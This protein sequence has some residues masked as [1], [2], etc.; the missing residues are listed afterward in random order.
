MNNMIFADRLLAIFP[1]ILCYWYHY[2]N[3]GIRIETQ[4]EEESL[5]GHFLALL[6]PKKNLPI[7][8]KPP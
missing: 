2:S 6:H 4:S 7:C 5:A 1:A 8:T 3:E